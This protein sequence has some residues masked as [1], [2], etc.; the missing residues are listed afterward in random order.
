[1]KTI[2]LTLV[3]AAFTAA[4]AFADDRTVSTTTTTYSTGTGT[5]NAYTPG[6]SF[7]LTEPNGPVTYSYGDSVSYVTRS[8]V[9]LTPEQVQTRIRVGIPATVHY[10]PMGERRVIQRVVV[11]DDDDDDDNN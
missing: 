7:I 11:D 5:I 4:G 10:A 1:M 9:V 3:C 6:S 8:G 2:L